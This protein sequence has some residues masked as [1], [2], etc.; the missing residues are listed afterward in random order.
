[1]LFTSSQQSF[2]SVKID[3]SIS[4]KIPRPESPQRSRFT[5]EE[6]QLLKMLVSNQSQPK[7]S[8]IALNFQNRTARQC[9]ERYNNYLRPDLINGPWTKEEDDLLIELFQK[10]G[11]KWSLISQ[12][13]NSRSSVNIKNHLTSLINQLNK[14]KS[15]C[16]FKIEI[17]KRET[18]QNKEDVGFSMNRNAMIGETISVGDN[19][20]I[21]EK[22]LFNVTSNINKTFSMNEKIMIGEISKVE[23]NDLSVLEDED[24]TF[25]SD[26]C[27]PDILSNFRFEEEMWT[28]EIQTP[29]EDNLFVF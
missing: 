21:N 27:F 24:D 9:R 1:M 13:F 29:E 22:V 7:W 26:D 16:I 2:P 18:K 14:S 17:M 20:K 11:P 10:N 5:K 6:D 25:L 19:F 15:S 12:S 8:E 4:D 3:E 28:N 23:E